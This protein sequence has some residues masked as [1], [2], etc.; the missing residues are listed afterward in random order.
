M[1]TIEILF[2]FLSAGGKGERLANDIKLII[3]N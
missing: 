1:S 2:F 3:N